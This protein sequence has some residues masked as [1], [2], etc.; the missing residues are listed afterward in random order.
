MSFWL[1]APPPSLLGAFTDRVADVRERTNAQMSDSTS[2]RAGTASV[3][4]P[5]WRITKSRY[6]LSNCQ[7]L[8]DGMTPGQGW[9]ARPQR[10]G[11]APSATAVTWIVRTAWAGLKPP[12]STV[13]PCETCMSGFGVLRCCLLS[14]SSNADDF[15]AAALGERPA[16]ICAV[17][18]ERRD[19]TL[20]RDVRIWCGD[21]ARLPHNRG[22]VR[23]GAAFEDIDTPRRVGHGPG[24]TLAVPAPQ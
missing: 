14:R 17:N 11:S 24:K 6:R 23:P 9:P 5:A 22:S 19:P 4:K 7:S 15:Y 12:G 1:S 20:L 16:R 18:C 21:S 13:D 10:N 3:S 2:C 8:F